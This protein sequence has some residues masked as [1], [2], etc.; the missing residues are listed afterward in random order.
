[1]EKAA[2][3]W[4]L[5]RHKS[6]LRACRAVALDLADPVLDRVAQ[7]FA[8]DLGLRWY[9]K[10]PLRSYFGQGRDLGRQPA[11]ADADCVLADGVRAAD[12][13]Q[14][15]HRIDLRRRP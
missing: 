10:R 6:R 12:E 13:G 14:G 11:I 8:A 3:D 5:P 1:M 4:D 9:S 7:T 2:H 15:T